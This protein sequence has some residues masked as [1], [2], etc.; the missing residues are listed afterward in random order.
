[1]AADEE[2][3]PEKRRI[4]P[5]TSWVEELEIPADPEFV[6]QLR[7]RLTDLLDRAGVS[8]QDINDLAIAVS[9]A[10]TNAIEHAANA[11]EPAVRVCCEVGPGFVQVIIQDRGRKPWD[12]AAVAP[13]ADPAVDLN[14][15]SHHGR[16]IQ[17]MRALVDEVNIGVREDGTEVRLVKKRADVRS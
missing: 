5:E 6:S 13:E 14:A 15:V 17:F 11:S 3:P 9:E 1:M 10:V 4:G 12:P 7:L 2:I 8:P 16:G